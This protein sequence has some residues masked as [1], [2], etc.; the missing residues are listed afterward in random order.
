[1]PVLVVGAETA[2]GRAAVR[3]LARGRGEVRAFA[4]AAATDEDGAAA[5]RA[6]GAKVAVGDL[7]DEAHLEAAA[8]QVHTVV[9]LAA[10]PFG[11]P[12]EQLDALATTL[13]A[14]IG[15]QC[16]RIVWATEL[17]AVRPD[18]NTYLEA[19]AAGADLL[20]GAPLEVVTLRCGL[21]YAPEDPGTLRLAADEPGGA[22]M[23]ARHAPLHVRD[24]AEAV[25][26]ADRQRGT[27]SEV[28]L[29][30]ELVGPE[31]LSLGA[32]RSA[33]REG[34]PVAP[35]ARPLPSVVADWLSRPA[36]G[37]PQALGRSGTRLAEGLR[38]S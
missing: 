4:D 38:R 34:L 9:H 5:L 20:A 29:D 30:V 2:A 11:R 10:D 14:A 22:D 16:R 26:A 24:L 18:G 31:E 37:G 19:L 25:A 3:A 17:A 6:L 32:F 23:A 8:E 1:M 21:R 33:L 35:S 12:T 28:H 13:S 27:R 36:T 7:D 15:A